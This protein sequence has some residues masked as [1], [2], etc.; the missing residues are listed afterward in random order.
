MTY[1][2][3]TIKQQ[4]L[5]IFQKLKKDNPDAEMGNAFTRVLEEAELDDLL[6]DEA[7]NSIL[8]ELE[9]IFER[10]EIVTAPGYDE[11][12]Y[13]YETLRDSV[14]TSK[15]QDFS[16]CEVLWLPRTEQEIKV[17][18]EYAKSFC[19]DYGYSE[20]APNFEWETAKTTLDSGKVLQTPF[21]F[22]RKRTALPKCPCCGASIP[23]GTEALSRYD[24]KTS[25]CSACGTREALEDYFGVIE[26]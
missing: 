15:N 21:A 23:E 24:N 5:K 16:K 1:D 13:G 19:L 18:C 8:A 7:H 25:I 6:S 22:I 2:I 12:E 10:N 11:T 17:S 14:L 3:D 26:G 9:V 4:T 20:Q